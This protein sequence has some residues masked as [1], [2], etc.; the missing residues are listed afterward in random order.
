M[1]YLNWVFISYPVMCG[2]I[3]F[4]TRNIHVFPPP[5]SCVKDPGF[6]G[7]CIKDPGCLS[8][9]CVVS[10]ATSPIHCDVT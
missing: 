2:L 9:D 1:I 10:M 8:H 6:P 5:G 7:S 4:L 3:K